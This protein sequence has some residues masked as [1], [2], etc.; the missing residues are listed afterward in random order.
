MLDGVFLEENMSHRFAL[1]FALSLVLSAQDEI[2]WLDS[3]PEAVKIAKE[4]R[5]PIFVEFRCEA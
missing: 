4:K 1:L 5:K 3:Y 2:N